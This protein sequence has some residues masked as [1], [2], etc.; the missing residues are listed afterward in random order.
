MTTIL[1]HSVFL[2]TAWPTKNAIL[3]VVVQKAILIME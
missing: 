1:A 2:I 3:L